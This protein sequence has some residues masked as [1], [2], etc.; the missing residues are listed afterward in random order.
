[1]FPVSHAK[2]QRLDTVVINLNSPRSRIRQQV[3]ITTDTERLLYGQ[4]T[5]IQIA[6]NARPDGEVLFSC[7][8]VSR[9]C[10][11]LQPQQPR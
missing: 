5:F 10:S 11:V 9:V 4:S 3:N 8:R 2:T 6:S 1:M 7:A